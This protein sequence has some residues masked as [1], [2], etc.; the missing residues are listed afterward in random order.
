MTPA[1]PAK[2]YKQAPP[3]ETVA[4]LQGILAEV[5]IA[6][7]EIDERDRHTFHSSRVETVDLLYPQMRL[8]ANG[9][10]MTR[11]YS[12]ASAHAEF[13]ERLQ[14]GNLA[15]PSHLHVT[16]EAYYGAY[17]GAARRRA[18]LAQ[19]AP[20]TRFHADPREVMLPVGEAVGRCSESLSGLLRTDDPVAQRFVLEE[21]LG[22]EE[23]LCVPFYDPARR[24]EVLVPIRLL[25]IE[26][27]SNGMCA[28][29]TPHEAL[30][31]G[32]CELFERHALTRIFLEQ[33]R[34]PEI[35]RAYFGDAEIVARIARLEAAEG[36]RVTVK[37][38][39]LGMGL[40]IIGA[41]IHDP[42]GGSCAF[43]IGV[44]P[45]P[46]TALERCLTEVFQTGVASR[47]LPVDLSDD[48]LARALEGGE[49]YLINHHVM[50][51]FRVGAVRF[52]LSIL[53]A[54]EGVAFDG[55]GWEEG[56]DDAEDLA[57]LLR[58]IEALGRRLL[59]RDV[60][61]LGFPAYWAY[62]P[63]MSESHLLDLDELVGWYKLSND[64]ILTWN[65]LAG[66][67]TAELRAFAET[68]AR[69]LET[70]PSGRRNPDALL[71]G[72]QAAAG[73]SRFGEWLPYVFL[74]LGDR[75]RAA[76]LLH[77][78]GVGSDQRSPA[79]RCL[80]SALALAA[81]G[82]GAA[83]VEE[84]LRRHFAELEVQA[85]MLWLTDPE[86][87]FH[88]LELPVCFDCER[89]PYLSSCG[90]IGAAH[91]VAAVKQR[92]EA[93][94]PGCDGLARVFDG[95]CPEGRAGDD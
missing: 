55:S 62:I 45:S 72:G 33:P 39:S 28:G 37:D 16:S 30:V 64:H 32:V 91:V 8:G 83:A 80:S 74:R 65:D 52:P 25:E 77:V 42:A 75:P 24:D 22:L 2:P 86:L 38:C 21:R 56:A 9:K 87:A 18:A 10:G 59:V 44:A 20:L 34:L 69:Y 78:G 5:G 29:N 68:A 57:I 1:R 14:N 46:A 13:L 4:R 50:Q 73:R 95:L 31:Q 35:P 79:E 66:A 82:L 84:R 76:A 94:P 41:L 85:A 60:S 89:C 23:V 61:F 90:F 88:Q 15:H 58:R 71:F 93:D 11:A 3:E 81:S 27:A 6:T 40:P 63:G 17:P 7:V 54:P 26:C 51:Y 70:P 67:S 19:R 36:W 47:L 49:M 53:D 12:S 48:P 92:H 43:H